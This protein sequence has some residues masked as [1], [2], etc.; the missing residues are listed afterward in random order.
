MNNILKITSLLVAAGYVSV[1]F[2]QS[3]KNQQHWVATW[4][5]S[6]TM[7]RAAGLGAGRAGSGGL[8]GGRGFSGGRGGGRGASG[9]VGPQR[10]FG[11]PPAL[12][13]VKNQTVRMIVHS[14]IGGKQVRVRL[15]NAIGGSSVNLGAAHIALRA[16]DSGIVPGSDRVLTFGGRGTATLYQGQVLVSDPV[17]LDV[18]PLG[19]LAVSLYFPGDTGTPTS[20]TFGLHTT[21]IS[22]EGDFTGQA[23]IVDAK[24]TQSYYWLAGIDV[25]APSNAAMLV[26][27]G[28]SIT[29]GDQ[30]TPDTNGM[31]PAVL[32][33]R[34]QANK[35][36]AGIGVVNAGIA[37]NRVL[38]EGGAL[39]RIDHDVIN[40]PGAKWI[41]LLEG[42]ND[43]SGGTRANSSPMLTSDDLI[44]A[45]RQMI[46]TAHLHGLKIIGCTITPYGGSSAYTD[47]GEA[48]R[49]AVND[50]IRHPGNFDAFVDFD[51]AVRDPNNPK[52][53]RPEA[54]SP[55]M[56]HPGDSGYKLM[57]QSI[58]LSLFRS[59]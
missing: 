49:K 14:S 54:D 59:R 11:I 40:Q 35:A 20:H 24:T 52:Q 19:D 22:K 57:G 6:Q 44:A 27:F 50:W 26:T 30:S 32:A 33:A 36:T 51:A 55:D 28:D 16:K 23:S 48:V 53:F 37:G 46:A 12:Q 10:R 25:L 9:P 47:A 17:T 43:I 56:L 39:A 45:Y 4:G 41:M 42:I 31:W 7:A 38:G 29:D 21:Y 1:A 2:A 34:L 8:G 18:A 58:D 13:T 5:T 15:S 3:N